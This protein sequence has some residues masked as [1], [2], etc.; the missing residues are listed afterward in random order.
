[1]SLFIYRLS[2]RVYYIL[3]WIFPSF[4]S[5]AKKWISGRKD[6]L[7]T[8]SSKVHA[9][10]KYIWFH[11]ASV[12]E[13]EQGR[14]L[15]DAIREQY[16]QYKIVLTFFSP[17]GYELRKNFEG[18]NHVFY[19]PLDTPSNV[20]QF[21]TLINPVLAVFVKYE[22]WVGYL[23]ELK[24]RNIPAV[25]ISAKFRESQVFFK[26][27]G[28]I[29]LKALKSFT[30]IFVQDYDSE[31]L[32]LR[33]KVDNVF[34]ANDTRF[35]RVSSIAANSKPLP[36]IE[37]FLAGEK[38]V[39]VAG[40][41]WAPDEEIIT[42]Y[43]NN[44]PSNLKWIIVPHEISQR[45]IQN[46][47]QSIKQPAVLYSQLEKEM[48][49]DVTNVLIVDTLG[50][51]SSLYSYSKIAYV[52]GGFGKGIHNV[53]EAAVYGKPVLF[54][55]NYNK[56]KEAVDLVNFKG[57]FC[58]NNKDDFNN[59]L[60]RLEEEQSLYEQS[61]Q[62]SLHYVNGKTGGTHTIMGKLRDEKLL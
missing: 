29:F 23:N 55:P 24:K 33:K 11:C 26:W 38:N 21:I 56:F 60:K 30:M 10:E 32:L 44:N 35:D 16:P 20:S 3:I 49:A 59:I 4:N 58:I 17:S 1:M 27:Y 5:K 47:R 34:V 41:T 31:K 40:S 54:G 50:I 57:A 18:V 53:L 48:N 39:F 36:L 7:Q 62:S 15:I 45:H 8:I 46:L 19:L 2:I 42:V 28:G 52:G 13:F 22:F 25:L 9:N 43:I 61:A 37:K 51:L 12:G 6:L 14:P